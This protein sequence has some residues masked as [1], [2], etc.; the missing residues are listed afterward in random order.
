VFATINRRFESSLTVPSMSRDMPSR[1][2]RRCRELAFH[3]VRAGICLTVRA[4]AD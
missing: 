1:A 2:A 3:I 4:P